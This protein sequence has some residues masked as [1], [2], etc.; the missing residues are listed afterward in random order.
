MISADKGL[1]NAS[2]PFPTSHPS[3]VGQ[4]H[5]RVDSLRIPV[6]PSLTVGEAGIEE[7]TPAM[8]SNS[9][10]SNSFLATKST[11]NTSAATTPTQVAGVPSSGNE[12]QRRGGGGPAA[13][14]ASRSNSGAPRNG[15]AGRKSHRNHR[16]PDTPRF[17]ERDIDDHVCH[18]FQ[19]R[20]SLSKDKN[21]GESDVL[22]PGRHGAAE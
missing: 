19:L 2:S 4:P 20:F 13:S 6:V 21:S 12:P 22:I 8:S 3:A 9:Q 5:P 10:L 14:A 15:Q 16:K 1:A 7:A 18:Y 17:G 11:N